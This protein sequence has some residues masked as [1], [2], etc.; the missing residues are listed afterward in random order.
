MD[1]L[2]PLT[3]EALEKRLSQQIV[4][5]PLIDGLL[6]RHASLMVYA[7]PSVGKSVLSIQVAMQLAAGLPVFGCL[8]VPN[9][10]KIWYIQ[11]ERPDVE[12]L[13][14]MQMMRDTI[15]VKSD[16][17]VLDTELQKL[18]FL[19]ESHL[20]QILKRGKEINAD[21]GFIDPLYGI[22]SGL[23]KD[24][25]A[26]NLVKVL[27]ILKSVLGLTLWINHHPVKD[28]YDR[29]GNRVDK[30]D[31]FYGSQWLKAHVT[32]SYEIEN[33]NIGTLWTM[34]KDSHSNLLRSIELAFDDETFVSTMQSDSLNYSDRLRL[35]INGKYRSPNR[36]FEFDECMKNLGCR[37]DTL[38]R[39][40]RLSAFSDVLTKV[41]NSGKRTVYEVKNEV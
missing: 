27:T 15:P 24:E 17:F 33:I 36:T 20:R 40:L 7:Q 2:P 6:Y 37:T 16:N 9:P 22:A 35:Y 10:C 12:S 8:A 34:K 39:A 11:M 3:G 23:S 19:N 25:I 28:S 29:E 18:N 30:E 41:K 26:S 13:E 38:R 14:R 4:H 31:P 32:G 21:V 5:E 1:L